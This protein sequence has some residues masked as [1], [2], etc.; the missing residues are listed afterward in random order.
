MAAIEHLKAFLN[1]WEDEFEPDNW[2]NPIQK[3]ITAQAGY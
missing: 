1:W 3:V 2:T